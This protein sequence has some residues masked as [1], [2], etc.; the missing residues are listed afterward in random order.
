MLQVSS[1]YANK[2]LT[3]V[4]EKTKEYT[5]EIKTKIDQSDNGTVK[6]AKGNSSF[7]Q[8]WRRFQEGLLGRPFRDWLKEE[9]R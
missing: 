6:Y 9:W 2:I 8:S 4:I 3:P 7:I 5:T 1:E